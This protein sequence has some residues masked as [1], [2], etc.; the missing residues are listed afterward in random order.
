MIVR[1]AAADKRRLWSSVTLAHLSVV[2]WLIKRP[3]HRSGVLPER[4]WLLAVGAGSGNRE[5]AV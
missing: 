1:V 4:G 2:I 3:M 5:C